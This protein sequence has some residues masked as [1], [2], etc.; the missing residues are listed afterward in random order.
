VVFQRRRLDGG[1]FG[2]AHL[3]E[4]SIGSTVVVCDLVP[5]R[6]SGLLVGRFDLDELLLLDGGRYAF[7]N[8][9]ELLHDLD[10]VPVRV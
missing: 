10:L 2:D 3:N 8:F 5:D 9:F 4:G 7:G 6:E 1:L